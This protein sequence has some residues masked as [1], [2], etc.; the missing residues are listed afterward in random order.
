MNDRS[1]AAQLRASLVAELAQQGL[2]ADSAWRNAFAAVPRE[3]F[4]PFYFEPCRGRPGWRLVERDAQ[5]RHGVYADEA[6]VTQLGGDDT[7]VESARRG[8]CV[9]ATPTSS[10]SAPSLMA[11]MLAA[12]DVHDGHRVLEVGTGTGYNAALLAHRLGEDNVTSIEVDAPMAARA[13]HALASVGYRPRVVCG[14]G[15]AGVPAYAPYDRLIATVALPRVPPAWLEQTRGDALLLIPLSCAG[16]GGLMALL[17]RE[18]TGRASGRFLA[19]Y[20]GFMSVRN[21][22]QPPTPTIRPGLLTTARP[23]EVPPEALND[24]HPAAFHLSLRCSLMYQVIQ[25]TPDDQDAGTQTWGRSTDGSTFAVV[26]TG[27]TVTASADG[28]IWDEIESAYT[29]WCA[30]G[31]P[32]R[33][34]FGVTVDTRQ[35][36]WLDHPDHMIVE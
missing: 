25:F 20:G 11:A 24:G 27:N 35:W 19:Q 5:W 18:P 8:E 17:A 31:R 4:V 1:T 23:T 30:L 34:R 14:D 22:P 16:H 36:V 13:R 6:L 33:E 26:R 3:A 29:E 32:P 9:T 2:L 28:P 15:A 12:L 21:A 7:A 10:S